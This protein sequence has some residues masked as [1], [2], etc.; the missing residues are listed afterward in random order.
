[1]LICSMT[2]PAKEYVKKVTTV[3]EGFIDELFELYDE[4][5]V[6]QSDFVIRLNAV[7]EM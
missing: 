1:M 3:P 7:A 2:I 6:L 5:S 4:R